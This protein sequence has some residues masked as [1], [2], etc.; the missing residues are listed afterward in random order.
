MLGLHQVW[1]RRL[2]VLKFLLIVK[3]LL[4]IKNSWIKS[5]LIIKV[6]I[7]YVNSRR[8]PHLHS[9]GKPKSLWLTAQCPGQGLETHPIVTLESGQRGQHREIFGVR[10]PSEK[11]NP[12][13]CSPRSAWHHHIAQQP[14]LPVRAELPG[15]QSEASLFCWGQQSPLMMYWGYAEWR[16]EI[17]FRTRGELGAWYRK[18]GHEGCW[19]PCWGPCPAPCSYRVRPVSW[20]L[21]PGMGI[22]HLRHFQTALSAAPR[23]D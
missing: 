10:S 12:S 13:R 21:W 4:S 19:R 23:M 9:A 2:S 20:V 6:I 16:W 15:Q 11:T 5:E 22:T 3:L 18:G 8:H 1:E 17:P 14:T 7:H